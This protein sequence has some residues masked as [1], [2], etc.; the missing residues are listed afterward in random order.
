M[1]V[2]CYIII[3]IIVCINS[4]VLYIYLFLY[5]FKCKKLYTGTVNSYTH[6]YPL[7]PR[8]KSCQR[9]YSSV[10]NFPF[11]VAFIYIDKIN[12]LFYTSAKKKKRNVYTPEHNISVLLFI[13]FIY[14]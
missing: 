8:N 4:Y 7:I 14:I 10:V 9:F 11:T 3:Y 2:Y 5:L 12:L 13:Q 6:N 1:Y